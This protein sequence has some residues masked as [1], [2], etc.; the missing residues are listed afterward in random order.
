MAKEKLNGKY[1]LISNSDDQPEEI[2]SELFRSIG[3]VSHGLNK[4]SDKDYIYF[5]CSLNKKPA[6]SRI[7]NALGFD[8]KFLKRACYLEVAYQN[9]MRTSMRDPLAIN[10]VVLVVNDKWLAY[11]LAEMFKGCSVEA[12]ENAI[13]VKVAKTNSECVRDCL[14]KKNE[15]K[16]KKVPMTPKERKAKYKAKIAAKKAERSHASF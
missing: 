2:D 15:G 1:L 16:I 13:M 5:N 12:H 11:S 3:C 14:A 10:E 7:L 6:H 4:H 9:L 8:D